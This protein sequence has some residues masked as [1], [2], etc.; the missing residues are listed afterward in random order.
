MEEA[1]ALNEPA[2]DALQLQ[3]LI[4]RVDVEEQYQRSQPSD[5]FLQDMGVRI[6]HGQTK[7]RECQRK[8]AERQDQRDRYGKSPEP[9][10]TAL[11]LADWNR[12][13]PYG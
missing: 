4:D 11:N 10:L 8:D 5:P 13:A 6:I 9:P 2:A 1:L 3:M 7:P 12:S